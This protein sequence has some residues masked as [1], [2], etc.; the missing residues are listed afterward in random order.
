MDTIQ[1]RREPV[2]TESG[3][4][5]AWASVAVN[6]GQDMVTITRV[7]GHALVETTA[8]HAQLANDSVKAL[9]SPAGDAIGLQNVPQAGPPASSI[10][11]AG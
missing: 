10:A 11:G 8:H 6:D 9:A 2:R 7:L 4:R 1:S 3:L 5:R